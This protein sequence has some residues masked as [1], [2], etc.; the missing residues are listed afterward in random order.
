MKNDSRIGCNNGDNV[1]SRRIAREFFVNILTQQHLLYID[2]C[3]D[4]YTL[5]MDHDVED[6]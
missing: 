5:T 1:S 4:G 2:T 6:K 3:V